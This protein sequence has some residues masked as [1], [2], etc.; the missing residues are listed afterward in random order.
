[1]AKGESDAHLARQVGALEQAILKE[2]I[3]RQQERVAA[4]CVAAWRRP[5]AGWDQF[6][7]NEG[8]KCLEQPLALQ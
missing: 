6:S 7:Q 2:Q 1:M 8:I 4:V 5:R 3:Q